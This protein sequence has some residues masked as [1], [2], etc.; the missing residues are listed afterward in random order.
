MMRACPVGVQ[1]MLLPQR[2]LASDQLKLDLSKSVVV[3]PLS[4]VST[5][6]ARSICAVGDTCI[7]I[8]Y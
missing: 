7:D 5:K 3:V 6:Y 2:F 1:L 4:M 8:F